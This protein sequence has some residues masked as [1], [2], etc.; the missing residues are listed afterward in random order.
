[1]EYFVSNEVVGHGALPILA[2]KWDVAHSGEHG[3]FSR[4]SI[5][6]GEGRAGPFL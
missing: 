6:Q 1:M 5:M 2:L 3:S 4:T